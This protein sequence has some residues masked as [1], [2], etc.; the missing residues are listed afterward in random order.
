MKNVITSLL[1]LLLSTPFYASSAPDFLVSLPDAKYKA[2]SEGKL[3]FLKFTADWCR[4]C[5]WMDEHTFTDSRIQ[6]YINHN[7]VPVQIN[8][9]DFDGLVIKQKYEVEYLPT[10]IIFNS[11]GKEVAR[12]SESLGP[13]RLLTI[14]EENN[15]PK[16]KVRV[17]MEAP[18]KDIP[19][20][21]VI[22]SRP[23]LPSTNTTPNYPSVDP[24]VVPET[25]PTKE[26]PVI[27]DDSKVITTTTDVK[28]ETVEA[29]A[30]VSSSNEM[31]TEEMA[32]LNGEGIFEI[33]VKYQIK[34]G[35]SIQ[36]GVFAE[37]N[38]VLA[39]VN[40]FKKNYGERVFVHIDKMDGKT[41][42]RLLVGHFY[43]KTQADTKKIGLEST[44][45]LCYVRN[46]QEM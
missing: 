7:Y 42:Y 29:S 6:N 25:S 15:K 31:T 27:I 36:V 19:V 23:S 41:V 40:K 30:Y 37:Y 35:F 26:E 22:I 5:Q 46:L 16:N 44:G 2:A 9:D 13:S 33:D 21:P 24:L 4:P 28:K 1:L 34:D 12:F 17:E 10:L 8:V 11:K 3:Y 38:N 20:S 14:L 43:D 32:F 39:E 18:V 45:I